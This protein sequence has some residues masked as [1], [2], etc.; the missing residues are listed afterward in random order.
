MVQSQVERGRYSPMTRWMLVTD[1]SCHWYVIPADKIGAWNEWCSIDEDDERSWDAP[2]WAVGVGG[3]PSLVTFESPLIDG[4][5]PK[6]S[7]NTK[8]SA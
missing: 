7:E 4:K 3:S 2:D 8:E 5:S 6:L 1:Q